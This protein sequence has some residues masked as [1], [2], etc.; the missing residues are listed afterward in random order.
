MIT[1]APEKVTLGPAYNAFGDKNWKAPE[2]DPCGID[3]FRGDLYKALEDEK[4]RLL[5]Q[6]SELEKYQKS[7][8]NHATAGL[9]D[10][11]DM[12]LN[13]VCVEISRSRNKVYTTAWN[14][15][16]KAAADL[17]RTSHTQASS[18][19]IA[20]AIENDLLYNGE[21]ND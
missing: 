3:F 1:E 20:V 15:A 7:I 10:G 12:D 14:A 17:A 21:N 9:N 13:D 11:A 18:K 19:G 6:V 2:A 4:E 8:V 5:N 16:I